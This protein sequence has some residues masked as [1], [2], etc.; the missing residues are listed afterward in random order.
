MLVCHCHAVYER[1]VRSAMADGAASVAEITEVTG[2]G[3]GCGGCLALLC[4][5]LPDHQ[6]GACGTTSCV[7]T[8]GCVSA[9]LASVR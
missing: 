8:R 6:P 5:L 1:E 9:D 4:E 3:G 7:R 2:A